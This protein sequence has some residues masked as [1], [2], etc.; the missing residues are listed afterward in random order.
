MIPRSFIRCRILS[1]GVIDAAPAVTALPRGTLGPPTLSGARNHVVAAAH[2]RKA[3]PPSTIGQRMI[4]GLRQS[5][6][7]SSRPVIAEIDGRQM[8]VST[9]TSLTTQ[10]SAMTG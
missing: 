6:E 1:S 10:T 5:A 9:L 3:G 7:R 4:F 8:A 2:R